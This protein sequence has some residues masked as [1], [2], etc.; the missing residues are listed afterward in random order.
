MS[1]AC[2]EKARQP[3]RWPS[4]TQ[5]TKPVKV[6]RDGKAYCTIHDPERV[7]RRMAD[8]RARWKA[9]DQESAKRAH[10]IAAAPEMLEALRMVVRHLHAP[11]GDGY[12]E[13]LAAERA[14]AKAEGRK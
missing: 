14:I 3:G 4:Y 11:G 6:T 5:C 1:A 10:L 12:E 7:A 9:Q 2:S 13:L 8:R